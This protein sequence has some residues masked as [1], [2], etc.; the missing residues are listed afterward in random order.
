MNW[1]VGLSLVL[2]APQLA[3]GDLMPPAPAVSSV[4]EDLDR[5]A[6]SGDLF[7]VSLAGDGTRSEK[8][9][10]KVRV[11]DCLLMFQTKALPNGGMAG[12]SALLGEGTAIRSTGPWGEIEIHGQE[13]SN[14][15]TIRTARSADAVVASLQAVQRKCAEPAILFP[16][17]GDRARQE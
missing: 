2:A 4:E 8:R 7:V 13:T 15:A 1:F 6:Q 11:M 12:G 14:R 9:V 5:L 10:L 16:V 17:Q 3:A